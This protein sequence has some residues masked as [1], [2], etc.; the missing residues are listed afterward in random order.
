MPDEDPI[1]HQLTTASPPV[2]PDGWCCLCGATIVCPR[3]PYHCQEPP[4]PT[5]FGN[6]RT[7]TMC[8]G[9]MGQR[10]VAKPF[11]EGLPHT[12]RSFLQVSQLCYAPT[13]RALPEI[14]PDG[15]QRH[16]KALA[17]GH[18]HTPQCKANWKQE[19]AT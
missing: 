12:G 11:V 14:V 7:I 3:L 8:C 16:S 6:P 5:S 2:V 10:A 4:L 1:G 17:H 9:Q 15:S 18:L 19:T 13:L